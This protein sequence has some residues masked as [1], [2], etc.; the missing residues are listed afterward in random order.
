MNIEPGTQDKVWTVSHF[1][2]WVAQC[3]LCNWRLE[4]RDS[5]QVDNYVADS[6]ECERIADIHYQ[7]AH[8]GELIAHG[9]HD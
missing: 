4:I 5:K 2:G 1:S 7:N 8:G 3:G 9:L 6:G